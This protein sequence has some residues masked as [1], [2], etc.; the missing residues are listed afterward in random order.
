MRYARCRYLLFSALHHHAATDY[1]LHFRWLTGSASFNLPVRQHARLAKLHPHKRVHHHVRGMRL[2]GS[3]TG[4][5]LSR[6]EPILRRGGSGP[7]TPSNASVIL[8][9]SSPSSRGAPGRQMIQDM[10]MNPSKAQHTSIDPYNHSFCRDGAGGAQ[11]STSSCC[12][13]RVSRQVHLGCLQVP[14][15]QVQDC[16]IPHLHGPGIAQQDAQPLRSRQRAPQIP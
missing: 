6:A 5:S 2:S 14:C 7:G 1:L 12:R 4:C 16:H 9:T 11:D 8:H 13:G 3:N 10:S 15:V